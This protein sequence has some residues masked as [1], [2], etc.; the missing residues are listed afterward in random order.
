MQLHP[1]LFVS[2][3][4]M[5]VSHGQQRKLYAELIDILNAG[6]DFD[7]ARA[8]AEF[9]V[10]QGLWRYAFQRPLQYFD[11]LPLVTQFDR[12]KLWVVSYLEK[13]APEIRAELERISHPEAVGFKPVEESLVDRGRWDQVVF[14]EGG[15]RFKQVEKHFPALAGILERIPPEHRNAGVIMLSWLHP[16]AHIAGHCGYTNGRLRIHLG[17]K[18]PPGA[19]M[20]VHDTELTWRAGECLV[21]D[22]SIEHEVWN[23]GSEPRV[24]LLFDI[25]HPGLP[26]SDRQAL[27]QREDESAPVRRFMKDRGFRNLALT[28]DG[29]VTVALDRA[30]ELFV[31]RY[32]VDSGIASIE[33]SADDELRTEPAAN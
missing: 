9:A 23:D 16:G 5:S 32:L 6:G 8:C 19:R 2:R 17:L 31:Q 24:I 13:H 15:R 27:A 14:Y 29:E 22:D 18:I 28:R 11:T 20:R 1:G 4:L 10:S 33:L 3:C 21:F 12:R 25:F 26:A 30:T 7:H